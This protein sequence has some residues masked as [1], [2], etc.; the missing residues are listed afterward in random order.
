VLAGPDPLVGL[1]VAPADLRRELESALRGKLMRLR[2]AYVRFHDAMPVLGGFA[3]ASCS[4]LLVL[5]RA[6]AVL[7]GRAPGVT[8]VSAIEALAGELGAG[9][10]AI[11]AVAS[12][13]RDGEW[14]CPPELFA[15]YLEAVQRAADLVDNTSTG[16][17]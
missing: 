14:S 3:A 7:L 16:A 10:S 5:L 6:V 13:R 8:A 1:H 2:Q 9:A 4:E 11:R 15:E 17:S 12:H